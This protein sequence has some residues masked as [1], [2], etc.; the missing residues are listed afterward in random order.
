MRIIN[1]GVY[2]TCD[3]LNQR[4]ETIQWLWRD[5]H[6]LYEANPVSQENIRMSDVGLLQPYSY[7]E[8]LS[9]SLASIGRW[10]DVVREQTFIKVEFVSALCVCVLVCV[11]M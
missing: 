5:I 3:P 7:R 1:N 9:S 11:C 4:L 2:S 10:T 6:Q 8:L